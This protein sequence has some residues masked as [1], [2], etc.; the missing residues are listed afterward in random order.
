MK[1]RLEASN[2]DALDDLTG[3][4]KWCEDTIRTLQALLPKEATRDRLKAD[5][6]P[7]LQEQHTREE[8]NFERITTVAQAVSA[9]SNRS[10][11]EVA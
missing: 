4:I 8:E 5:E 7:S 9:S 10:T 3:N 6:V 1:H 2:Q 11:A